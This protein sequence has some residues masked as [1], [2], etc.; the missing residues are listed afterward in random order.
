[1]NQIPGTGAQLY[2]T[3]RNGNVAI[4]GQGGDSAGGIQGYGGATA[5]TPGVY[6]EGGPV[7]GVGVSGKGGGTPGFGI[8]T[9]GEGT[10]GDPGV[11]G[12]TGTAGGIG[13]QGFGSVSAAAA[14]RGIDGLGG[15]LANDT[16]S[17]GVYGEARLASN[18]AGVHGL[19]GGGTA[20]YGLWGQA[21][22]GSAASGVR[23]E[24][25]GIGVGV[26]GF[27]GTSGVGVQGI[28]GGG[29][30]GVAGIS[31]GPT[32]AG[33]TGSSLTNDGYGVYAL[34]K[35]TAPDKASLRIKEQEQPVDEDVGAMYVDKY[36]KRPSLGDGTDW[37][38]FMMNSYQAS[39]LT[40]DI[41]GPPSGAPWNIDFATT[42]TI[43]ANS[44]KVGSVVR[45]RAWGKNTGASINSVYH[46]RIAF[47][48]FEICHTSTSS[49][50]SADKDSYSFSLESLVLFTVVGAG[51]AA[52]SIGTAIYGTGVRT[53]IDE[54]LVGPARE[55]FSIPTNAD[56]LIKVSLVDVDATP[57]SVTAA[58]TSS[59]YGL[60]VDISG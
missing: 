59:L 1:M 4:I 49:P 35:I 30:A 33:V 28:G 39:S 40:D 50:S 18:S 24:G 43:P 8:G 22:A 5:S 23:G 34:G 6:G 3:G 11:R 48:A 56:I 57:P 14:A 16:A 41:A 53:S 26:E 55:T 60:V 15:G 46:Y 21:R 51:G 38:G 17:E 20:S 44:L 32:A 45:I 52:S 19:G 47:G 36:T 10:G 12:F 2:V 9:Q 29:A 42:Y 31:S 37:I 7:G 54:A 27:G 58:D 25:D 13:V